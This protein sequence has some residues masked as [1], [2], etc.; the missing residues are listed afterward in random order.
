MI[1]LF[2]TDARYNEQERPPREIRVRGERQVE[3]IARVLL[4]ISVLV[5]TV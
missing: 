5:V 4:V 3:Q 2:L 1:P